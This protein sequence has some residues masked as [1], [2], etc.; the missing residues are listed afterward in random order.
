MQDTV[1]SPPHTPARI[2]KRTGTLLRDEP[3]RK[4]PSRQEIDMKFTRARKMTI[5][6]AIVCGIPLTASPGLAQPCASGTD[7]R[8]LNDSGVPAALKNQILGT[9]GPIVSTTKLELSVREVVVIRMVL[10]DAPINSSATAT[11]INQIFFNSVPSEKSMQ[12]YFIRNSYVFNVVSGGV[13]AWITL[14]QEDHGLHSWRRGNV[15]FCK[16]VLKKADVN[17]APSTPTTTT[18][19]RRRSADRHPDSQR[20]AGTGFAS[21]RP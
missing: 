4:I 15:P 18:H 7:V 1:M 14:D 9:P 19:Q 13:P 17:W 5:A 2:Y 11:Y 8:N 16:D 3:G 20:H 12:G 6:L 21:T 10:A